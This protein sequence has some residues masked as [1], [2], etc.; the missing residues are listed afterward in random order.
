MTREV[1]SDQPT[2]VAQHEERRVKQKQHYNHLGRTKLRRGHKL[3]KWK[4]GVVE[5]VEPVAA[6]VKINTESGE[7]A[8]KVQYRVVVEPE[9]VYRSALNYANAYRVFSKL[10]LPINLQSNDAT[11]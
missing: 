10:G 1:L 9:A 11:I 5:L 7:Q 6:Q 4:D 3:F 2:R 8:K